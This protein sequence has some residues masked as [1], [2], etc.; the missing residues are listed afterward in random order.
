MT[1]IIEVPG[2]GEVEFPDDMS[3]DQIS[4]A[5]K[6]SLPQQMAAPQQEKALGPWAS[7]AVRPLAKGAAA[8][9]LM[10]MDAG[11]AARNLAES[12]TRKYLPKVAQMIDRTTGGGPGQPYELPSSMFNRALDT[13][14]TKPE[15]V[16]AAAEGVSSAL[17][18]AA[19]PSP[20]AA[21]QAP[22]GFVRPAASA[23]EE[24]VNRGIPLTMGQRGGK[25][26]KAAEDFASNVPLVGGAIK[27]RQQEALE[28]WNRSVLQKIDANITKG[29]KEGFEQA[30][31]TLSR[32]YKSIWKEELPYNRTGLRDQWTAL[33]SDLGKKLPKEQADEVTETLRRHFQQVLSGARANGTQGA[34]LESVD[35]ALRE[36]AKKASRAGD[37]AVAG[38]YNKARTAFRSQMDPTMNEALKRTDDLYMRLSVLRNAAKRSGW[39]TFTPAQLLMASKRKASD[40]A[41]A[42]MRAPFQEEALKAADVLG[43]ARS[44]AQAALERGVGKTLGN[45][46]GALALG[47]GAM[48]DFGTTA[49]VAGLGRLAYSKAGQKLLT[50]LPKATQKVIKSDPTGRVL[51]SALAQMET[52]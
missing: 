2:M 52:Q 8:L 16:G 36:A 1:Q 17:V 7:A 19:V 6:S 23:K 20:Q 44:G 31:Q 43:T 47:G 26:I 48:A 34:A 18:G 50:N 22:A 42:E 38:A 51:A 45:T 39:E 32:A 40:A 35:D 49:T 13:Y 14:T 25:V 33:V 4:A 5:I 30:G 9:P 41:V 27:A 28:A 24:F 21:L 15:G 12:G 11:V 46:M 10:A 37:G 29:G 3:D